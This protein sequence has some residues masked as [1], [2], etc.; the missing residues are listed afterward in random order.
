MI[1]SFLTLVVAAILVVALLPLMFVYSG[2]SLFLVIA[3]FL[4][5]ATLLICYVGHVPTALR[6]HLRKWRQ[7]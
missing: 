7:R 4:V 2:W 3:G 1:L 5:A 6:T